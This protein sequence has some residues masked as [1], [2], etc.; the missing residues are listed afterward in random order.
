MKK[1][2]DMHTIC[3]KLAVLLF[4][5][6]CSVLAGAKEIET[7][8]V[9][10]GADDNAALADAL[11]KAV[12][13]VNGV[14]SSLAVSTGR[15]ELTEKSTTSTDKSNA[16]TQRTA[17][18]AQTS[19]ARMSAQGSIS[20]YEILSTEVGADGRTKVT[21]KAFISRYEAP[22]Y[23]AP[24]SAAARKRVAIF[25]TFSS[26]SGFSFFGNVSGDELALQVTSQIESSM[27]ETGQVSLLDRTTLAG[28]LIELG[29]IGSN[30]TGASEKAKLRQFRGADL[31][32]MATIQ[33][34]RRIV[35]TRSVK[36][37]GQNKS[38]VDLALDIELRAVVPATGE[39]LLIKRI[40]IRDAVDREDALYQAGNLAA[41]DVV[42]ALTGVAP[43]IPRRTI[44]RP[45][46]P[47]PTGP[48]RSGVSLPFDR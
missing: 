5:L 40:A 26:G 28:T 6:V 7:T 38:S 33:N 35:Q 22:T 21:V 46:A 32:V 44:P 15:L 2:A 42:N 24:G 27:I 1:I 36:S 18:L 47:E 25:P 9:G 17:S 29:L 11:A 34:A 8:A 10:L 19:D 37:T 20:R 30:L 23:R 45:K 41:Y 14:R 43:A 13:Q 12:A 4:F 48:R 3:S 16:T 31:I 39:L